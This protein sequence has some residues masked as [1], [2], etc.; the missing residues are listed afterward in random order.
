MADER[1]HVPIGGVL[2]N[3]LGHSRLV[4]ANVG[5]FAE[6][7]SIWSRRGSVM[8]RNEGHGHRNGEERGNRTP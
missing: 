1:L 4:G 6:E 5:P 8:K 7:E 3:V 2:Q